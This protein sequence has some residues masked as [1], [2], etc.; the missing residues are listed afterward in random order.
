MALMGSFDIAGTI[1]LP[2]GLGLFGFIE[3]CSLGATL[4]FVKAM[5]DHPAAAKIART[6]IFALTRAALIGLLGLVATLVGSTFLG[7]QKAAW[8]LLGLLYVGIGVL[9]LTGRQGLIARSVGP[10]F[11]RLDSPGGAIGFG[12]L[13]GLNIPACAAPLLLGLLGLA[14][15]EG[16]AGAPLFKGFAVLAL[17]GLA[18]SLPLVAAVLFERTRRLLDRLTGLSRRL[19]KWTG[20]LM[21]GLGGWSI[22]FAFTV[23]LAEGS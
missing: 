13:F 14:A 20:L 7:F 3:P 4:V 22:W 5:E 19:P 9:Y 15:A 17:F 23:S 2:V 12:L 21:L 1:L 11:S 10:A 18:L 8:G 6:T 16:A